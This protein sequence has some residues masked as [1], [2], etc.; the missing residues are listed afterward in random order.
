MESGL[1]IA[2]LGLVIVLLSLFQAGLWAD[3]SMDGVKPNTFEWAQKRGR[4]VLARFL[5][6]YGVPGG[7]A[8]F[9]VGLLVAGASLITG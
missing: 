1:S 4:Q 5:R 6:R 7:A 2:G 9:V 8:L 3:E